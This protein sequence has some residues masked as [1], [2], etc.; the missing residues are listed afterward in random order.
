MALKRKV[1]THNRQFANVVNAL[2]LVWNHP[3][4]DLDL[5]GIAS[6]CNVS[7]YHFHRIFH[8]YQDETLKSYITRKRL[9]LA[10]RR[11]IWYPNQYISDI[12][13]S[14]G[15]SSPANFSKAFKIHFGITA[16]DYRQPHLINSVNDSEIINTYGKELDP[17]SFYSKYKYFDEQKKLQRLKEL[18]KIISI[19]KLKKQKLLYKTVNDGLNN[20]DF[21][22]ACHEVTE[23]G[24][25]NLL[26]WKKNIFSVWYDPYSVCPL[27]KVRQDIAIRVPLS[28]KIRLPF[29]TQYN[30]EG[31]YITGV[32]AGS[33]LELVHT[34]RDI[35]TLWLAERGYLADTTPY[36]VRHLNNFNRDGFY[37]L[38]FYIKICI[39]YN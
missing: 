34:N 16:K 35:Y 38:R 20:E 14:H 1:S 27:D 39:N 9:E 2:N 30:N 4:K 29:M 36:Y 15:F 37:K 24:K 3:E 13:Q 28:Q 31:Y 7:K 8:E 6:A 11:L 21:N 10:A 32:I 18:D 22:P 25:N 17:M 26:D 19:V 12:A 5:A 23:W 33:S